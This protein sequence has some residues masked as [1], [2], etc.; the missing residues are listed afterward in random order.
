MNEAFLHYIWQHRLYDSGSLRTVNGEWIEVLH[1][2]RYNRDA[3]PDFFNA[4][5]RIGD[6]LWAGNVE[7][8]LSSSDWN[9][10]GHSL[11]PLYSNCILHV[12]QKHDEDV[13][14][15]DH[16][17]LTTLE[18]NG[19]TDQLAW[20]RY[21]E[22]IGNLDDIHC[23][24]ALNG[25]DPFVRN[26]W[27][28]RM[29][30]ERL[31]ERARQARRWLDATRN[32]WEEAFY[33]ALARN[34]G[35]H[36]NAEPFERLA[37]SIPFAGM[38][39][40]RDQALKMEALFFGQA[41]FLTAG[42]TD[43]YIARLAEEFWFLQRKMNLKP[44]NNPGWKFLRLRPVNFPTIRIA[45]FVRLFQ[46]QTPVFQ[47]CMDADSVKALCDIFRVDV[48]PYWQTHF[49]PGKRSPAGKKQLG[50]SSVRL[51]LINTVVPFLFLRGKSVG[52]ESLCE[53]AMHW[54]T[55]IPP[56]DNRIVRNWKVAGWDPGSAGE[57][58]ALLH[59]FEVYC[60]PKNCLNCRIGNHFINSSP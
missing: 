41:G 13:K 27:L 37:R 58:Q 15:T 53:K 30:I 46:Q 52:D 51:I 33:L 12:V 6:T 49:L 47:K 4:R 48:S 9:K 42:S 24:D 2:G 21:Q 38:Q 36:I 55:V 11:D 18:L 31:E 40:V 8:H 60:T 35:F 29:M 34:F 26:F 28:D 59:L 5:I 3:G 57:S 10:H 43:Q 7:I 20:M 44:L 50:E 22:L 25:V 56:E 23:R 17:P 14:G 19:K 54:L 32:N 45:Q 39:R 1:P 16:L